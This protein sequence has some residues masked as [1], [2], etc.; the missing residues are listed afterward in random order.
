[1]LK[2]TSALQRRPFVSRGSALARTSP[3]K[4]KRSKARPVA[5]QPVGV[6]E[7]VA[8]DRVKARSGGWCEIQMPGCFGRATDWH[9]RKNRSQRG[10]WQASNGLHACRWCHEH[11]TDTRGHRALFEA[12][13]WIVPS[14]RT[15]A[16]VPVLLPT[17]QRVL[18]D[19]VGDYLPV[20]A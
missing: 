3:L 2:R 4:A 20:A 19:D 11:V 8:R 6:G 13:G 14:H 5:D 12:N 10:L 7:G 15:P 1:M 16:E 9:H 18:L 17:G